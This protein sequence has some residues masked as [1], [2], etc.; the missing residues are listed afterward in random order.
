MRGFRIASAMPR[1][2]TAG[3]PSTNPEHS[4]RYVDSDVPEGMTLSEWRGA[5]ARSAAARGR[6]SG[7]LRRLGAR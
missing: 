1:R 3:M 6:R 2:D 4:F 7:L 5:K